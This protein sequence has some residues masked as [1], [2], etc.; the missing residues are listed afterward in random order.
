MTKSQKK[1]MIVTLAVTLVL[2][3]AFGMIS[4][5]TQG[6]TNFDREVNEANLYGS[7]EVVLVDSNDGNGVRIDVDEETGA[8]VLNGKAASDL[9]YMVATITLDKGE[10]TLEACDKASKAGVYLTAEI[11]DNVTYF[12]FTPG[13]T[14][15][16][17]AD[18][19]TVTI[20]L[21]IADD[22]QLNNVKVLPVI[23]TGDESVDFYG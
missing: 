10:Y 9:E 13:N 21:Y 14:L 1:T 3:I 20:M 2:F 7:A 16:I 5:M 8:F 12:D 22:V 18:N 17:A 11:G 23:Y 4:S 15:N 6:F 19:T